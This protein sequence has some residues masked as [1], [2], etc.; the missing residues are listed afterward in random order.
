MQNSKHSLNSNYILD[1]F[2]SFI[3]NKSE[4]KPIVAELISYTHSYVYLWPQPHCY[5]IIQKLVYYY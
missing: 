1:Q 5:Y 3:Q 2:Y 4:Q